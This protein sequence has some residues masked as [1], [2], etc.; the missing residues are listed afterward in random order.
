ML[1][2]WAYQLTKATP[3]ED[4]D[5]MKTRRAQYKGYPNAQKPPFVLKGDTISSSTFWHGKHLNEWANN[6]VR[7]HTDGKGNFVT[8]AMEDTGTL[9]S[10]TFLSKAGK[11]NLNKVLV[12]RTGSNFSMEAPGSTAARSLKDMRVGAYSAYMPALE[13]A[14]K[15]GSTVLEALLSGHAPAA[16]SQRPR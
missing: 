12:L 8:T 1:V 7:Y 13:A 14:Y 9:Q 2:E 3:L 6:W 10:L 15:V 5:A 4:T 16:T 11:V